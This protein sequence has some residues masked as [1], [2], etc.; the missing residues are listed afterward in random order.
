MK[1]I[2]CD[3]FQQT[4]EEYLIRHRSIL[5]ILSKMQESDARV[6]RAISKAVTSCGCIRVSAE[7]QTAP[8]DI[9]LEQFK[10]HMD[11]HVSGNLCEH[12]KEVLESEIGSNLFYMAALCN[13]L[14]LNLY[15]IMLKEHKKLSTLRFF[16]FT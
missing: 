8:E 13:L 9:S 1:D 3:G 16:N 15:D 2:L 7:R 4:V 5:D 6:N 11:T 12:C 14:H 10:D